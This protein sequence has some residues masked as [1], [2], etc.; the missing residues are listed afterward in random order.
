MYLEKKLKEIVFF[1]QIDL[2]CENLVYFNIKEG[3]KYLLKEIN[4][5]A[6]SKLLSEKN[7]L[8]KILYEGSNKAEEI[9]SIKLKKIHE[10]VGF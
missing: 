1:I 9:A 10:I 7:Y 4:L 6:N 5:N 3:D 8:D 2:I